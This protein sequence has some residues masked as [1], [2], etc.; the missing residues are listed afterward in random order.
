M[1][2]LIGVGLGLGGQIDSERGV[3]VES[4]RTGWQ[5]VPLG[6]LL[7]SRLAVPVWID[8]DVNAFATA[9]RLVGRARQATNL[10]VVRLG[11]GVGAALVLGGQL[12][13]AGRG[14]RVRP[15]PTRMGRSPVRVRLAGLPRGLRR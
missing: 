13:A 8:N 15:P 11:R 9:E 6:A 2:R 12:W 7:R 1:T 10:A 4:Y 5:G 14:G 3:C